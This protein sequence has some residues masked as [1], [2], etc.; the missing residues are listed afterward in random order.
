MATCHLCGDRP[1]DAEMWEHLRVL[2]PDAWGDG[3][4]RWPDGQPV[5]HD[6]TL[7]ASDFEEQ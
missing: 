5:I 1:P 7:E 6:M 2:H 4:E 3:P